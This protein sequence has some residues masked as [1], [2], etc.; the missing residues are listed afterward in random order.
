MEEE[1]NEDNAVIAVVVKSKGR[2]L[3]RSEKQCFN[4]GRV[5]HLSVLCP[6]KNHNKDAHNPYQHGKKI[7]FKR[8]ED[9]EAFRE[10]IV[11]FKQE[12]SRNRHFE[13]Q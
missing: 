8:E 6:V 2:R 3:K 1:Q 11:F 10:R 7:Q 9:F 13:D 4:C 5:G 12:C